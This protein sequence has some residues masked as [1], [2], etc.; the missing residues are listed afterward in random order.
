MVARG[1]HHEVLGEQA[2]LAEGVRQVGVEAGDGQVAGAFFQFLARQQATGVVGD[3]QQVGRLLAQ[4]RQQGGQQGLLDVV[5]GIEMNALGALQEI[6]ALAL[7]V[8]G[9]QLGH[10]ALHQRRQFMGPWRWREAARG[11]H[12]QR[13]AQLVAQLVQLVAQRR[14]AQRHARGGQGSAALLVEHVE[15]Q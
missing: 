8:E 6:A 10:Q 11:A 13:I 3:Q 5:G 9:L 1:Q 12:E 4:A 14:L 15:D 7:V 2:L